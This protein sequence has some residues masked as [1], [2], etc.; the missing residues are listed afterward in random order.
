V[1]LVGSHTAELLVQ[2]SEVCQLYIVDIEDRQSV[3][4]RVLAD[5]LNLRRK[6]VHDIP[7]VASQ[8]DG[9]RKCPQRSAEKNRD[10]TGT[11][12]QWRS[13]QLCDEGTKR[14]RGVSGKR[15]KLLK[16]P[17]NLTQPLVVETTRSRV[18]PTS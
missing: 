7:T 1:C 4:I 17:P 10:H 12:S 3:L 14:F 11:N 9:T 18:T 16:S 13:D 15:Q 6:D 5:S 2:G 8:R